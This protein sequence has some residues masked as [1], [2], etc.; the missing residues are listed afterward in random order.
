MGR[1]MWPLGSTTST[2]P[3]IRM[4]D[5]GKDLV[6]VKTEHSLY[7]QC[8]RCGISWESLVSLYDSFQTTRQS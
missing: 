6:L 7:L 8:F 3:S 5:P 1:T 4:F 2:N